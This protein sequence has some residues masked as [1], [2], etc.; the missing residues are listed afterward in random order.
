MIQQPVC[1][2]YEK[3]KK[4]MDKE[5]AIFRTQLLFIAFTPLNRTPDQLGE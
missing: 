3:K 2:S 1:Y 5:N 4:S